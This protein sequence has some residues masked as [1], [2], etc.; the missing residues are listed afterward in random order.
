[1]NRITDRYA[2]AVRS[3]NLRSKPD[4]RMSDSDVIGAAGLAAKKSPLA[5]ALMRLFAGDNRAAPEIVR[6]MAASVIGKAW[7]WHKIELHRLEADDIARAVLAW[8]RDGVCKVC[9]GHG[10]KLAGNV[11]IGSGRA[12]L[13]DT[14]CPACHGT[15][16]VMFDSQF[17]MDR[18]ELARWLRSEI[19]R[20]QAIAGSEAMRKLGPSLDF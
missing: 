19:E 5:I 18:L 10:Y 16:K 4:T 8:H 12:V 15:R 7:H 9:G 3:S 14:P 20:E 11:S 13:G 17:A 1:M 2:S 6:I